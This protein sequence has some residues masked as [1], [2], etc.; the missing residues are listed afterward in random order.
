MSTSSCLLSVGSLSAGFV[1]STS[2]KA[3]CECISMGP[4]I[5]G[6]EPSFSPVASISLSSVP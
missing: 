1:D 5:M 4:E 3:V 2:A 6:P